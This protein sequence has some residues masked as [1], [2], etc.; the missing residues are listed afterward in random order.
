MAASIPE[1]VLDSD[2]GSPERPVIL[3]ILQEAPI[4]L[5]KRP[6]CSV[7]VEVEG[8][9]FVE[10]INDGES[11]RRENKRLRKERLALLFFDVAQGQS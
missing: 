4:R 10:K 9:F 2:Q 7:F 3:P 1:M 11:R 6:Y 5:R 8:G